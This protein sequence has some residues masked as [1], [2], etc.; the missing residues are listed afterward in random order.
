MHE[1]DSKIVAA[2]ERLS[3]ALR[4][5]LARQARQY[6]LSRLQAQVLIYLN[7]AQRR[8]ATVGIHE[9]AT[10][11]GLVPATVSEAVATLAAKGLLTK[12]P[13]RRDARAVELKLSRRGQVIAGKLAGWTAEL[14]ETLNTL[15]RHQKEATLRVLLELIAAL[16][17]HGRVPYVRMC[18]TCAYFERPSFCH[19]LNR[20]LATHELRVDCPDHVLSEEFSH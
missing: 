5:E 16:Q 11:F 2:L 18:L 4:G 6:G 10:A 8:A 9:L 13:G 1:L 7:L 20:P 3:E 15:P 19:L 14:S 17:R 12:Q